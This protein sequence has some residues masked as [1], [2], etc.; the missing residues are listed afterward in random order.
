MTAQN[1]IIRIDP[2]PKYFSI[3]WMLGARC[4]YE[5]MY[6]PSEY[7]DKTSSHHS[8]DKL[9]SVWTQIIDQ[10][11]DMALEYKISF[12]GGEVTTNKNFLPFLEWVKTMPY[13]THF[14]LTTNG[15]ASLN[16][17]KRLVKVL[18]GITLSTHGEFID[19]SKFF[20]VARELNKIMLK[21]EKSLHVNIM[22]EYWHQDRMRLYE[23]FCKDHGI[24]YSV[25]RIDYNS[26]TRIEIWKKG[27][28]DIEF[29]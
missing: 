2:I 25:N 15:S 6:C 16:Y 12:T 10:T 28:Y 1:K 18:D 7:H 4:N 11:R 19:E 23:Q 17:Y 21:P 29:L 20:T 8:L 5:C 26:Q 13:R 9:K 27:R 24:S 3:T 22:D 14:F